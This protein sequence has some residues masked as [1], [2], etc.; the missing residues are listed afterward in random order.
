MGVKKTKRARKSY[1]SYKDIAEWPQSHKLSPTE[2]RNS[3][4]SPIT[5]IGSGI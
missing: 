3:R 2:D 4:T 1:K 5:I